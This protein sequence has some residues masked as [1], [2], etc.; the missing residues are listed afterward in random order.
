MPL[1]QRPPLWQFASVVHGL[2]T[3]AARQCPLVVS[4]YV[5]IAQLAWLVHA[6]PGMTQ[7]CEV[8]SQTWPDAHALELAQP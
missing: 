1:K 6:L 4:Q 3:L 2:P 8:G 5:P 7:A